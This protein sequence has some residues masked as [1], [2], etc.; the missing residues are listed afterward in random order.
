MIETL[1]DCLSFQNQTTHLIRF[2]RII[3]RIKFRWRICLFYLVKDRWIRHRYRTTWPNDRYPWYQTRPRLYEN[4]HLSKWPFTYPPRPRLLFQWFKQAEL[5]PYVEYA[6]EEK[7]I[8]NDFGMN[9]QFYFDIDQLQ[10]VFQNTF[11]SPLPSSSPSPHWT[12]KTHPT[13]STSA[14][15]FVSIMSSQCFLSLSFN[16]SSR[17]HPFGRPYQ[18]LDKQLVSEKAMEWNRT[19]V[20]I[21]NG[22]LL[23]VFFH[24]WSSIY[25]YI[26][27]AYCVHW[28]K[29]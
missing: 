8:I 7:S 13:T 17:K 15:F 23:V 25:S 5:P 14:T 26:L 2:E 20:K 24:F 3:F 9:R 6:Q 27:V 10:L 12:S 16:L 11:D 21:R 22:Y 18:E 29:Q 19:T 1:I 4:N 28:E